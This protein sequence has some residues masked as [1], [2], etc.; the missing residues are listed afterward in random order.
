MIEDPEWAKRYR[1]KAVR[2]VVA[3]HK[4]RYKTDAQFRERTKNY[5]KFNQ[6]FR[7]IVRMNSN[8][9]FPMAGCTMKE[10]SDH[11]E[12]QFL[13]GMTWENY[14]KQWNLDHIDGLSMFD[15]TRKDQV[16]ACWHYK[17]LR[18]MWSAANFQK[19]NGLVLRH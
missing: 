14:G 18:P 11:I 5:N 3:N 19:G 12:K 15:L 4:K 9:V 7:Q 10:L 1:A 17:N 2:N 8:A 6:V 16:L 13:P